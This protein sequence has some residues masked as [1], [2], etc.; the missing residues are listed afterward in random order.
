MEESWVGVGNRTTARQRSLAK[1]RRG[2][3]R[4]EVAIAPYFFFP[5]SSF[6]PL[7][8]FSPCFNLPS[9]ILGKDLNREIL[10]SCSVQNPMKFCSNSIILA[11]YEAKSAMLKILPFSFPFWRA[12]EA[13]AGFSS[14]PTVRTSSKADLILNRLI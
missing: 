10:A 2:A 11:L 13:S 12:R 3:I 1:E 14:S 6:V 7:L 9:Y 5:F 4:R 8:E